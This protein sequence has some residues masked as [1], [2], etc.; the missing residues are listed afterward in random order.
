M[1]PRSTIVVVGGGIAGLSAAYEL[2]RDPPGGASDLRVILIEESSRLG[3]KIL[4]SDFGGRPVDEG[5]DAF[6]ARS[7]HAVGLA[8]ELGLADL[9][10]P[11]ARSDAAVWAKGALHPL[12]AGLVLGIPSSL[13]PLWDSSLLSR[14]AVLRAAAD[15]VM[16][17]PRRAK[18]RAIGRLV[19]ARLG[20]EVHRLLVDPLISGINAGRSDRLSMDASTPQIAAGAH[21]HASLIRAAAAAVHSGRPQVASASAQGASEIGSFASKPAE[22]VFLGVAGGMGRM[23]E[24]L[25]QALTDRGVELRTST[26]GV[27]L[28]SGPNGW[29]VRT[30]SERIE[31]QGVV[32]ATPA[33]ATA[34]MLDAT[35]PAAASLLREIEYSSVT[36]LT[37][38]YRREDVSDPLEGSGF[39]V[40]RGEGRTLTACSW[41][42]SKWPTIA[43]DGEVLLRASVGRVDDVSALAWDREELVARVH[44]ELA[45]AVGISAP[46]TASRISAWPNGFP[47]YDLGHPRRLRQLQNLVGEVGTIALAG[48]AYSGVG[49]PACIASGR[50]AARAVAGAVAAAAGPS[51]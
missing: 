47:Q 39:L 5:P 11:P 21:S 48:A 31:A 4:T 8:R 34:S 35:L 20:S 49:I 18:D 32:L 30:A 2:V 29:T 9:L 17:R 27:D 26:V 46:P 45:E 25:E 15:L 7:P 10:I 42:S 12:P 40:P 24:A 13:G 3:G 14:R 43:L 28:S 16:P 51:D 19:R 6:V 50:S 23:V 36:L 44:A 38:S 37:L 33:F 1:S 41:A 22:S